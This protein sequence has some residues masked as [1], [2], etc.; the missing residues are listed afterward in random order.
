MTSQVGGWEQ[1][2]FDF[3]FH[4]KERQWMSVDVCQ[5]NK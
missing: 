5:L 1:G 3:T 4:E 2:T